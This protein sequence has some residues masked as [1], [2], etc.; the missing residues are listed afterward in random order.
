MHETTFVHEIFSALKKHME[1]GEKNQV[2]A[3]NVRLSPLCH[4]T[5]EVLQKTYQGLAKQH[6][7]ENVRLNV[8]LLELPLTCRS[9][10]KITSVIKPTF[11]CPYCN[12]HDIDIKLDKEFFV[13]SIE[14]LGDGPEGCCG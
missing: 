7:C 10:K 11:A 14:C 13:E 5:P 2:T 1:N 9:C 8:K 12:S 3:I 4:V 6:G